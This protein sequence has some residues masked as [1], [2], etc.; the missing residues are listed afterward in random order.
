[1]WHKILFMWSIFVSSNICSPRVGCHQKY[2]TPP[3]FSSKLQFES[4]FFYFISRRR[5]GAELNLRRSKASHFVSVFLAFSHF[6]ASTESWVL[7][8]QF[9]T[10]SLPWPFDLNV[11]AELCVVSSG[12]AC[13]C[14]IS[15][16][17]CVYRRTY[18]LLLLCAAEPKE[19]RT[20]S[21]VNGLNFSLASWRLFFIFFFQNWTEPLLFSCLSDSRFKSNIGTRCAESESTLSPGKM[22][23]FA[24]FTYL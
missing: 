10:S 24:S 22:H 8:S 11:M 21:F 1:M 18:G 12:P 23:L 19:K 17:L 16:N 4:V 15:H 6:V 13:I 5:T 3:G 14:A 7:C 2:S 20:Q 9:W